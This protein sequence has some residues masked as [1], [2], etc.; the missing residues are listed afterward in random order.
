MSRFTLGLLLLLGSFANSEAGPAIV[1]PSQRG[2]NPLRIDAGAEPE[3]AW[4]LFL[5]RFFKHFDRNGD[6]VLSPAEAGRIFPLP[7]AGNG[8]AAMDFAKLDSNRDS[9]ASPDEFRDFYRAA[10]FTPV[11]VIVEPATAEVLILGHALFQHLDRD[12]NGEISADEF[13]EAPLL[14]K[15]LDENEDEVLTA[16]EIIGLKPKGRLKPSG[17]TLGIDDAANTPVLSLA[18]GAPPRLTSPTGN[19]SFDLP[20]RGNPLTVPGGSCWLQASVSD[21]AAALRST[22]GFYIAQF[23]SIAGEKPVKKP[24]LEED[25]AAQVLV[26]LFDAADRDGD[27]SLSLAELEGFFDLIE[28]G[29]NC[30]LIVTAVDRG[31]NL[32]D[33]L[34]TNSNGRLDLPELNAAARLREPMKSDGIPGSYRIGH[35]RGNP[36][37]SFGPVPL[38]AAAKPRTVPDAAPKGPRWFEA[39]DRNGDGYVSAGEFLGSPELFRKLDVNGDGRITVEEAK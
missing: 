24:V 38:A 4:R 1:F 13:R 15:R 6:G 25:P 17:S 30:R 18:V 36:S 7:V 21:S 32:F 26:G 8:V 34:D 12:G 29:V 31:R 37:D 20:E 28:L 9:K 2:G 5:D 16:A 10:G 14:M 23:K 35:G 11:V 19:R 33:W 39:M 3:K 22:K 27:G